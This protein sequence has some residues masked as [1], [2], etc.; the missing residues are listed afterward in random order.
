MAQRTGSRHVG[1]HGQSLGGSRVTTHQAVGIAEGSRGSHD[2][3][4]LQ[5]TGA[6]YHQHLGIIEPGVGDRCA[7]QLAVFTCQLEDVVDIDGIKWQIAQAVEH[8]LTLAGRVGIPG[9]INGRDSGAAPV[10]AVEIEI[11]S[12]GECFCDLL[13]C[14]TVEG[15]LQKVESVGVPGV[16]RH[17]FRGADL[18]GFRGG[19]AHLAAVDDQAI[20]RVAVEER[21]GR[22]GHDGVF[23]PQLEA[24]FVQ[25]HGFVA[26]A[27]RGI[28]GAGTG[29]D[30]SRPTDC[31]VG[32]A[33]ALVVQRRGVL[34]PVAQGFAVQP[35]QL[36]GVVGG[37]HLQVGY[38]ASI[39]GQPQI[40]HRAAGLHRGGGCDR[41]HAGDHGALLPSRPGGVGRHL[42]GF[43]IDGEIAIAVDAAGPVDRQ[44]CRGG[45][46]QVGLGGEFSADGEIALE[47]QG[48][49]AGTGEIQIAIQQ[50]S[51]GAVERE[52]PGLQEGAPQIGAA[53]ADVQIGAGRIIQGGVIRHQPG[54]AQQVD[55][56]GAGQRQVGRLQSG[57]L[58]HADRSTTQ[59]GLA[60]LRQGCLQQLTHRRR[61]HQVGGEAEGDHLAAGR[62][63]G[64]ASELQQAGGRG[65]SHHPVDPTVLQVAEGAGLHAVEAHGR[66][67]SGH[68]SF[69]RKA[70]I[71]CAEGGRHEGGAADARRGDGVLQQQ[72][73]AARIHAEIQSLDRTA[74]HRRSRRPGVDGGLILRQWLTAA[75]DE[76]PLVVH[77]VTEQ[78]HHVPSRVGVQLG[79]GA[80]DA[81]GGRHLQ[82]GGGDGGARY[83]AGSGLQ[84]DAW[85][86]VAVGV[87]AG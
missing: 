83:Q 87:A 62:I 57:R 84:A 17:Y 76:A 65:R 39:K 35:H 52:R 4:A 44:V 8:G 5:S 34:Q 3:L 42:Y 47:G 36:E 32:E 21:R 75:I 33:A 70:V 78:I 40:L 72:G 63:T 20:Q 29:V 50:Q 26:G 41:R 45:D 46:R 61:A 53:A 58:G 1:F 9:E 13:T 18:T 38:G 51:A 74:A 24:D 81:T 16:A 28:D 43:G 19:A 2:R 15:V 68:R 73:A 54:L 31:S 27:Q 49:G 55:G 11:G 69:Q 80:Q 30:Q 10:H 12:R 25:H 48:G 37:V 22:E 64:A 14:W 85:S 6:R 59:S 71:G 79:I 66:A 7:A 86:R 77:P 67:L 60:A 82:G 56:A 23:T